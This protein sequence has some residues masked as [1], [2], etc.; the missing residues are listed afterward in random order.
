MLAGTIILN[1]CGNKKTE[2]ADTNGINKA[3]LENVKTVKVVMSN[4]EQGLILTGK[5]EYDPDKII[6]YTS[7]VSGIIEKTYFSLGDKVQKGQSLLDI[8]SSELS[9]LQ[10]EQI[11]LETE[12]KVAQR[13]LKTAQSLY[14]D[15][16]LSEI[17]L[18]EVQG[19]VRQAQADL[20]KIKSDMTVMGT[21]KGNGIFSIKS[22]MTGHIVGKNA[23]S[24]STL[25]AEGDPVFT[26][27]DLSTVWITANVYA[28]DL[29]FVSEGMDVEITTLSYPDEVFSGKINT[30]SQVFDP[31][32]KVLKAR[33]VMNNKELKFKPEMSVMV[34]L[35]SKKPPLTPPKGE[36]KSPLRGAGGLFPSIPSDALIFDDNRYF[37]V[38][39]NK[40]KEYKIREVTLQGHHDKTTY[41][42]SGLSENESIVVN[43]Q[44][45]IY[46]GLKE[47]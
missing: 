35:K 25:S 14:D 19:R 34:K 28:S 18:L 7:L 43:N 21:S 11:A 1:S 6:S 39:E 33:I 22:P 47:E 5:V 26:V 41:I 45:L 44:L 24:G 46:S 40:P 12:L 2:N 3:F 36:D 30:L 9:G 31:E 27:A 42:A 15:N 29:L 8:R 16:M 20:E 37:V 38:V 23:S 13:E 17:E 4:L 32:E 10:S